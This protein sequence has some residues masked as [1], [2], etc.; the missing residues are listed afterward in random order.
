MLHVEIYPS[1]DQTH[2]AFLKSIWYVTCGNL[3]LKRSDTWCVFK[4]NMV[5]YMWKSTPQEIRPMMRVQSQYSVLHVEIYPSWDQTLV[6]SQ[7][8]MLHVE[9]YPSRDQTCD[10]FSKSVWSVTCG[11]LSLKRSDPWPVVFVSSSQGITSIKG[12]GTWRVNPFTPSTVIT[13]LPLQLSSVA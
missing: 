7:Y 3:P 9:I 2:D 11:N 10:A 1:R 6:Q 8:S 4:V 13:T 5:C 12:I